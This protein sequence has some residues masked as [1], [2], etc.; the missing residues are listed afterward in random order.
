MTITLRTKQIFTYLSLIILTVIV[1]RFVIWSFQSSEVL[2]IKNSPV[3]VKTVTGVPES[4]GIIFMKIDYCKKIKATGEVRVSFVGKSVERFLPKSIDKQDPTCK[5]VD[6]PIL[7]P[8]DLPPGNY[9]VHF[10]TS[11]DINP[12]KQDIITEFDSKDF[13]VK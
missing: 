7:I 2:Q 4:K 9:H 8:V 1:A 3:P 10:R 5:V 12:I 13:E 6:L 11:Y